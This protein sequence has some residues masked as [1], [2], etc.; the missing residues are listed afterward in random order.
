MRTAG[1]CVVNA[2]IEAVAVTPRAAV[3]HYYNIHESVATI[4]L[5]YNMYNRVVGISGYITTI[6]CRGFNDHRIRILL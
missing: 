1:A 4:L 5:S 3:Y 2:G 6:Q